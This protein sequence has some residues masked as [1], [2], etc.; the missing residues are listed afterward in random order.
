MIKTYL[1][2]HSNFDIRIESRSGGIFTAISDLILSREGSVYGAIIDKDFNVTHIR[3]KDKATRDLMR[4]SK[5]VQSTIVSCIDEIINDLKNDL[6]VLF[7]GTPCQV[8]AIKRITEG[9]NDKLITLDIVCHGV[10]SPMILKDYIKYQEEINHCEILEIDF[11][12]K[13]K[14]G[15]KEHIETLECSNNTTIDSKVFTTLFL[16]HVVIRPS[17]FSCKYKN[18]ERIGDITIGDAWG[19]DKNN[20]DFNDDN[21]V[22]LVMINSISGMK[23]FK[24]LYPDLQIREVLIDDFLQ[25]PLVAN[26]QMPSSRRKF[27]KLYR[28]NGFKKSYRFVRNRII[29]SRI[30]NKIKRVLKKNW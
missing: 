23:I 13:K 10:P 8:E 30:K 16:E 14:Y 2:K 27:W 25:E 15:W 6:W 7:S 17:C 19:I 21:G 5:Y 3:A 12:N 29:K 20:I 1:V 28:K 24:E 9:Y 11:R 4:G 22:S 18:I 26:Y